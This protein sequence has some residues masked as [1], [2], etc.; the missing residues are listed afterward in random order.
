MDEKQ[1][2]PDQLI[3][4]SNALEPVIARASAAILA[5][6]DRADLGVQTKSDLSPVT[7]ADLASH[8]ILA[9]ALAALTPAWPLVSEED[10]ESHE[11]PSQA[12]TYWLLD[13]LDGTKEF[14]A[15]TG[16]FS[17]S[18]GLV[19][20]DQAIFGLLYGPI[21]DCLY[22][23]GHGVPAERRR[24]TQSDSLWEPIAAR[25][26][27][28]DGGVL[29]SSRR[30]N[31]RLEGERISRHDHLGSALKF[32]RVAEGEADLYIRRGATMEWDTC[33]GQAILEAAGGSVQTLEGVL[34]RYGKSQRLNHGFI[35]RGRPS[36]KDV[37]VP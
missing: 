3:R 6:Y 35:A 27:P 22:R 34:L 11:R 13:P 1:P 30:S 17:I 26:R 20:G 31:P 2:S 23:G 36:E 19:C 29:V 7:D 10:S 32:A 4:I 28:A 9:G 16:E 8:S 25:I 21:D 37:M 15:R 18:L 33:A 12:D 24:L 14:I 5:V